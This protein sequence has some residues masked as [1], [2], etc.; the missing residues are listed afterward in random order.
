MWCH[1]CKLKHP[2]ADVFECTCAK[3]YCKKCTARHYGVTVCLGFSGCRRIFYRRIEFVFVV[4][5]RMVYLC[6]WVFR[7]VER[8][9]FLSKVVF[10]VRIGG[11]VLDFSKAEKMLLHW[12]SRVVLVFGGWAQ[13]LFC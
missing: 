11:R 12:P 10:C 2:F 13:V 7:V 3:R 1:Q 9:D 8:K 6:F 4:G 5:R